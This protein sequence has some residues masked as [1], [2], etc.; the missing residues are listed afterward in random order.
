VQPLTGVHCIC[1]K[2]ITAAA[3]EEVDTTPLE[4]FDA[5]ALDEILG[6]RAKGLR[7]LCFLGYRDS[8]NDWLVNLTKVRKRRRLL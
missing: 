8:E 6:L 3:F 4:G 1:N 2:Q 7:R 5:D